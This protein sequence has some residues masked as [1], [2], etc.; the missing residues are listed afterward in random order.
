MSHRLLL[1]LERWLPPNSLKP[2]KG[3]LVNIDNK[4]AVAN[5]LHINVIILRLEPEMR[6]ERVSPLE[7]TE[8][9]LSHIFNQIPGPLVDTNTG[10]GNYED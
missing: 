10:D 8:W 7:R 2:S 1:S 6:K 5:R 3:E 4:G 9:L